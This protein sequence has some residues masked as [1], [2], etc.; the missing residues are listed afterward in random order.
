M[1]GLRLFPGQLRVQWLVRRNAFVV[2]HAH[3]E[4]GDA[5]DPAVR[6]RHLIDDVPALVE[7]VADPRH[8]VAERLALG[9]LGDTQ[10]RLALRLVLSEARRLVLD[11]FVG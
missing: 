9:P 6:E 11:A 4:V 1:A 3:Q 7:R 10:D 5:S 8:P 2:D